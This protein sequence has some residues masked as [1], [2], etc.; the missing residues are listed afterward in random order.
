MRVLNRMFA[1]TVQ[2]TYDKLIDALGEEG[3]AWTGLT[4]KVT[5]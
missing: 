1:V 4:D 3:H 2:R 5:Y